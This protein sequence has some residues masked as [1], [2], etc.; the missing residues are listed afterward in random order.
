MFFFLLFILFSFK[1][2]WSTVVCFYFLFTFLFFIFILFRILYVEFGHFSVSSQ[3]FFGCCCCYFCFFLRLLFNNIL[4]ARKFDAFF[5]FFLYPA[6]EQNLGYVRDP[7]QYFFFA[8]FFTVSL[9]L[10]HF[11]CLLLFSQKKRRTKWKNQENFLKTLAL[12]HSQT[13]T[14]FNM[15]TKR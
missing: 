12:A 8:F 5:C 11:L 15:C 2:H 9:L 14:H 10:A 3:F 6:H 13:H 7:I 1:N 4:V